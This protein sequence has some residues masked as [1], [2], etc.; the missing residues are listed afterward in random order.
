MNIFDSIW[1]LEDTF[2]YKSLSL[3]WKAFHCVFAFLITFSD[4]YTFFVTNFL[5]RNSEL[6]LQH[7]FI[8]K[9]FQIRIFAIPLIIYVFTKRNCF[10]KV[11]TKSQMARWHLYKQ[12]FYNCYN[13]K[14]YNFINMTE[15]SNLRTN[16]KLIQHTKSKN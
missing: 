11:R 6:F 2:F 14:S 13:S 3:L 10:Y 12:W 4:C 16:R 8:Y 1:R 7:A 15:N 9:H 5:K